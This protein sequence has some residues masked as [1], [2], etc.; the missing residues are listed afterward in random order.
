MSYELLPPPEPLVHGVNEPLVDG[1]FRV[2]GQLLLQY[3]LD[4]R[5]EVEE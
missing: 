3:L 1:D 2:Q 5:V 4:G